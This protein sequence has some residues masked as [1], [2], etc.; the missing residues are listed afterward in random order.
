MK[1]IPEMV[2]VMQHFQLGGKVEGC[3]CDSDEWLP[4]DE[5]SWNWAVY[6]YRIARQQLICIRDNLIEGMSRSMQKLQ[7]ETINEALGKAKYERA[8]PKL[9]A[10]P[11]G[12]IERLRNGLENCRLYAAR[13]RGYEWAKTILRFCDESGVSGSITRAALEAEP[14][15]PVA[16]V[17]VH[18]TG[19]NAGLKWSPV[20]LDGGTPPYLKDGILL[21]TSPQASKD[22]ERVKLLREALEFTNKYGFCAEDACHK[23]E[24]ALEKTK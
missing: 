4:A 13:T 11:T 21:Y 14:Q 22:A 10:E 16:V 17:R 19:G 23:M 1:T 9:E 8:A 2:I 5:P 20:G 12:E 7:A 15:E 24:E 3:Y 6:D 18:T